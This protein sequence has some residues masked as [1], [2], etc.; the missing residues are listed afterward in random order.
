[1]VTD[2]VTD[3]PEL[4][5]WRELE[6][7]A[8]CASLHERP[9]LG[10]LREDDFSWEVAR[11]AFRVLRQAQVT[12]L[13]SA[14]L[15]LRQTPYRPFG[16][17]AAGSLPADD[18]S[19]GSDA[20]SSQASEA[21]SLLEA[22]GGASL[23]R[24]LHEQTKHEDQVGLGRLL[25]NRAAHRQLD[26]LLRRALAESPYRA[27][28]RLEREGGVVGSSA[29]DLSGPLELLPAE[30]RIRRLLDQLDRIPTYTHDPQQGALEAAVAQVRRQLA[31][32]R[33]HPG[34]CWGMP[35]YIPSLDRQ[36]MGVGR[37]QVVVIAGESKVGKSTFL[38]RLALENAR[39]AHPYFGSRP[40]VVV[41]YTLEQAQHELVRRAAAY[42][43]GVNGVRL[44]AGRATAEELARFE[45]ALDWLE[46]QQQLR[47]LDAG[48]V[49]DID[50]LVASMRYYRQQE[51]AAIFVV[52]YLGLVS[53]SRAY[54][55]AY[56]G[57][58]EITGKLK[59]AAIALDAIVI[60]GAQDNFRDAELRCGRPSNALIA[61]SQ[62][63]VRDADLILH[64]WKPAHYLREPPARELWSGVL[65]LV[66]GQARHVVLEPETYVHWDLGTGVI[67]ELPPERLQLLRSPQAQE[68]LRGFGSSFSGGGFGW[69]GSASGPGG[70][71][72]NGSGKSSGKSVAVAE[73]RDGPSARPVPTMTTMPAA[74]AVPTV[75]AAS[76]KPS[77]PGRRRV[78]SDATGA[79][80]L[81]ATPSVST[82]TTPDE[83]ASSW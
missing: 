59:E 25:R 52:D 69:S 49:S 41:Y 32:E 31:E 47:I 54:R 65:V 78:T 46:A 53:P 14:E 56:E 9:G 23:L 19:R 20:R 80:G 71:S 63:V 68:C 16:A 24:S 51:G 36:V 18:E 50:Q 29:D 45:R 67:S 8:L 74:P 5:A 62:D 17:F 10:F 42:L 76:P 1:M 27:A 35:F 30:A 26:R 43:A 73:G 4:D 55:S 66:S 58:N 15:L 34:E 12:S 77:R 70:H 57:S 2:A 48:S 6:L 7:R 72:E 28:G 39:R 83:P 13:A 44:R 82:P 37:G 60:E 61:G 75:P 40:P 81:G 11:L 64:L 33:A 3:A 38:L 79:G 21:P 22:L